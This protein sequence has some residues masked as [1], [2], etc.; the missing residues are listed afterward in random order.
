[1]TAKVHIFVGTPQEDNEEEK[2][3][4]FAELQMNGIDLHIAMSENSLEDISVDQFLDYLGFV[5]NKSLLVSRQ[6]EHVLIA[7]DENVYDFAEEIKEGLSEKNNK[8]LGRLP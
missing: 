1:M 2:D 6:L 3:F 4:L 8:L 7:I 5:L